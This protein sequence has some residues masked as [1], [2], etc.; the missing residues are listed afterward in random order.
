MDL[1]F[2]SLRKTPFKVDIKERERERK[3]KEG[4]GGDGK[5][6][7]RQVSGPEHV[8][9]EDPVGRRLAERP[10]YTAHAEEWGT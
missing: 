8:R 1:D 3:K 4:R 6:R 2:S 5:G 7:E 10:V 9:E